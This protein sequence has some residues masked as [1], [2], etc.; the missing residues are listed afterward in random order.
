MKR[1]TT[2]V[3]RSDRDGG[4]LT[5]AAALAVIGLTAVEA[6]A[7]DPPEKAGNPKKKSRS[8]T[9]RPASTGRFNK[10]FQRC[11]NSSAKTV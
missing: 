3:E 1:R 2:L 9:H 11:R 8:E 6:N 5:V 7:Q 4:V 10:Q